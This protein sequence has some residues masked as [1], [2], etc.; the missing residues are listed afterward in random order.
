M[1]LDKRGAIPEWLAVLAIPVVLLFAAGWLFIFGYLIL[2]V[3]G[4]MR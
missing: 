2:A 1:R 4:W 3:L